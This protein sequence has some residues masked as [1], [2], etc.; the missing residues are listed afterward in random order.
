MDVSF[1]VRDP[2]KWNLKVKLSKG[3]FSLLPPFKGGMGELWI[4]NQVSNAY[5]AEAS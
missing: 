1:P 5:S 4:M 2:V 3:G